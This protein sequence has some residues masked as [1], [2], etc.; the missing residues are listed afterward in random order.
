MYIFVSVRSTCTKWDSDK[1]SPDKNSPQNGQGDKSSLLECS[2]V[3]V[4]PRVY[5]CDYLGVHMLTCL[6]VR[7]DSEYVRLSIYISV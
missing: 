1:S 4:R 3:G 2:F 7:I 5:N 6:G